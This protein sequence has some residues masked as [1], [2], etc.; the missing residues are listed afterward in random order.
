MDPSCKIKI[1]L[2]FSLD[3]I[4][5]NMVWLQA[6]ITG[7]NQRDNREKVFD[8]KKQDG[9]TKVFPSNREQFDSLDVLILKEDAKDLL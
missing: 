5:D 1:Y 4:N 9:R 2:E 6:L 7:G 3:K 8:L